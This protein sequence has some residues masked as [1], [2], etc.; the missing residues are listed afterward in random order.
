[1]NIKFVIIG[2]AIIAGL[3]FGTEYYSAKKFQENV[4]N[5][6]KN[7]KIDA[8]MEKQMKRSGLPIK[9]DIL[10][11]YPKITQYYDIDFLLP[12]E[13]AQQIRTQMQQEAN[14]QP[15]R[16]INN[17]PNLKNDTK[18]HDYYHAYKK[19]LTEDNVSL[20]I[21]VRDKNKQKIAEATQEL[22][23]CSVFLTPPKS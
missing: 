5:E 12:S 3:W 2:L 18:P 9:M 7:I 19:V 16:Y 10:N 11:H 22:A 14:E 17:H 1:M 6:L 21:I 23:K 15:C 13:Q 8:E 20:T 4:R